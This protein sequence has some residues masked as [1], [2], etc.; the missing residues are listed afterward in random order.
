V[1]F[2]IVSYILCGDCIL[3][4]GTDYIFVFKYLVLNN[5]YQSTFLGQRREDIFFLL[6]L[7]NF[8]REE[9]EGGTLQVHI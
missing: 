4:F 9:K 3:Y 6:F 2:Y 8:S 1:V 7:Q 5:W